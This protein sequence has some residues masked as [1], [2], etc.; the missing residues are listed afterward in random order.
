MN[1]KQRNP[2]AL[3]H[4]E[5]ALHVTDQLESILYHHKILSELKQ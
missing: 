5:V 4:S 3:Q 1:I 2:L